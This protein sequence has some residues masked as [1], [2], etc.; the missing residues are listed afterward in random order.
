[1]GKLVPLE[2]VLPD[3]L[4]WTYVAPVRL[5]LVVYQRMSL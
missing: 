1:M 5:L 2:R 4:F 3:E